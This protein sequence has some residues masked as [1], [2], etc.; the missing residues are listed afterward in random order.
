MGFAVLNPS[1]AGFRST[2]SGSNDEAP[3]MKLRR[4]KPDV[5]DALVK[6][7]PVFRPTT[8]ISNELVNLKAG[9]RNRVLPH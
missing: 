8:E 4:S 9:S 6:N 1:Y 7:V 2:G 3:I 5:V